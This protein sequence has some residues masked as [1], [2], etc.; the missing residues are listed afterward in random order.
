MRKHKKK[1]TSNERLSDTVYHMAT[2]LY[3]INAIDAVTM[4]DYDKLKIPEVKD[5]SAK[6][7]K[8]IRLKQKVSQAVF[9]KFLNTTVHTIREWEQGKKHPRGTSLKLL[10][11]VAN[12]GLEILV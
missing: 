6:E 2:A 3:D 4:R 12:K 11:L 9:A 7:I 5:Y 10:N 8:Y 1:L